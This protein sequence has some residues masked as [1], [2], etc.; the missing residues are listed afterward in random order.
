MD[1]AQV[2]LER[3][4]IHCLGGRIRPVGIGRILV[5]YF[6]ELGTLTS[7]LDLKDKLFSLTHVP[8]ERQKILGLVKGKL[9]DDFVRV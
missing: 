5:S 7:V 8:N 4:R 9:P 6:T 3:E 2:H 1:N